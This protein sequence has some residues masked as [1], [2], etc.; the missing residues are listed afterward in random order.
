MNKYDLVSIVR[1]TADDTVVDSIHKAITD[2]ILSGSG[3]VIE[4]GV[5]KKRK[6]AY[7]IDDFKEGIYTITTFESSSE[8]PAELDRVL[9]I[10][11]DVIRH[12]VLKMES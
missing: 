5:W 9:K 11:D 1:P 7:K 3:N 4:Q 6:L 10:S 8:V 12:K 2:V